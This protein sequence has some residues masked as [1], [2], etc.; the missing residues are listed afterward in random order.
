MFN[1]TNLFFMVHF[2]LLKENIEKK[3]HK[4]GA[5]IH[6]LIGVLVWNGGSSVGVKSP[7]FIHPRL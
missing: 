3:S 7:K 2:S 6:F 5:S 1:K 4:V